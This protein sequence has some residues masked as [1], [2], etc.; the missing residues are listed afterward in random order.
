L[1][2][3]IPF[4][5]TALFRSSVMG[6]FIARFEIA[7]SP[8]DDPDLY[9]RLSP[10]THAAEVRTPVLVMHATGDDVVPPDQA[11]C[12]HQALTALGLPRSEEHTSELQSRENL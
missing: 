2:S 9:A 12:W 11:E 3:S 4:P 10:S 1:P 7:A 6:E 8:Q 5:Y